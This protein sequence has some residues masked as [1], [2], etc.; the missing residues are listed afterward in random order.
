[1]TMLVIALR[2][3]LED[4]VLCLLK[5]RDVQAF[6]VI[7]R[8]TGTGSSGTVTDS[9]FFPGSNE[10]V[11]VVLPDDQAE[12]TIE[13]IQSFC[14]ARARTHPRSKAN[15]RVFTLPCAQAL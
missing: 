6:T 7:P 2:E 13:D 5:Q 1:M 9:P 10:M 4:D 14:Q 11:V 12:Q 15:I 8:V 3:S